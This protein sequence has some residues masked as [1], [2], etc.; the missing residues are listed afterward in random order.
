MCRVR[1]WNFNE[2]EVMTRLIGNVIVLMPPHCT[3]AT[4]LKKLSQPRAK[5]LRRRLEID[6]TFLAIAQ[7]L[8]RLI[9]DKQQR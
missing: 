7:K 1:R 9:L 6:C 8:R 4:Q 2:R 3:T 5:A